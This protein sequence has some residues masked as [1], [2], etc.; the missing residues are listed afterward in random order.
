MVAGSL[1]WIGFTASI[2][3]YPSDQAAGGLKTRVEIPALVVGAAFY[4]TNIHTKRIDLTM[5]PPKVGQCGISGRSS[6]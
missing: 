6:E 3:Y 4:G 1:L 5:E 2:I